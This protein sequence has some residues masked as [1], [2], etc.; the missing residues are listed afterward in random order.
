MRTQGYI[1][2]DVLVGLAIFAIVI[3]SAQSIS[4]QYLVGLRVIEEEADNGSIAISGILALSNRLEQSRFAVSKRSLEQVIEATTAHWNVPQLNWMVGAL[5]GI[6]IQKNAL[7]TYDVY[8]N[9]VDNHQTSAPK[10]VLKNQTAPNIEVFSTAREVTVQGADELWL[11][12]QI[13]FSRNG[14]DKV[15]ITLIALSVPRFSSMLC[16]ARPLAEGCLR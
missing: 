11:G 9:I 10:L 2:V 4:R 16:A 14:S 5:S 3:A 6:S 8:I 7:G 1:L 12:F 15:P 13:G